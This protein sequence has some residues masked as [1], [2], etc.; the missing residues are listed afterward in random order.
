MLISGDTIFSGLGPTDGFRGTVPGPSPRYL[1]SIAYDAS[2]KNFVLFGG[3]T[4]KSGVSGETW[5]FDEAGG[6]YALPAWRRVQPAH[7]PPPRWGAAM[8]FDPKQSV[9]LMYG[10]LI[11]DRAEGYPGSDTWAWDGAD[12]S[13]VTPAATGPGP[14]DG[15]A[16][17]TAGDGVLLFGGRVGNVSYFSDAFSWDGRNWSRVDRG[18]TPAGR[19]YAAVAWSPADAVLFVFGGT[20]LRSGAGPGAKGAPLSDGWELK[21]GSWSEINMSG[22]PALT[23]GNALWTP[24]TSFE[25]LHGLSCP[26]VNREIWAWDSI[27]WT[28]MGEEAGV[29]GRW[30]AVMAQD[31]DGEQLTFGGSEIAEC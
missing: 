2:H 26:K 22:P 13:D 16:M 19:A 1:A 6:Q 18:P 30:G 3:H 20:G 9:V 27:K 24:K 4:A 15:A 28:S 31:D 10:G 25:V 17:V 14:R 11:P 23:L 7:N 5:I 8:A 12:W 29:F 21:E